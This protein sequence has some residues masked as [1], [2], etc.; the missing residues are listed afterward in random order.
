[1]P[2]PIDPWG[3]GAHVGSNQLLV[4]FDESI[5]VDSLRDGIRIYGPSGDELSI[6]MNPFSGVG[7]NEAPGPHTRNF[8]ISFV[9]DSLQPWGRYTVE[10]DAAIED[11]FRNHLSPLTWVFDRQPTTLEGTSGFAD[12]FVAR[13]EAFP[14]KWTAFG[15]PR[16]PPDQPPGW[17]TDIVAKSLLVD[18]VMDG[19][20]MADAERNLGM[21]NK[22]QAARLLKEP[23]QKAASA[24]GAGSD[25]FALRTELA[26]IRRALPPVMDDARMK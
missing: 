15:D 11:L 7:F 24:Q 3:S 20:L 8:G 21:E 19:M 18:K 10:L 12:E 4:G 25:L 5:D 26:D 23:V 6:T 1:M 16:N 17:R 22:D 9:P 2:G 13:F 14:E